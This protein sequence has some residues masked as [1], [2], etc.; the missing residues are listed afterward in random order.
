MPQTHLAEGRNQVLTA[1]LEHVERAD[2]LLVLK[3]PP[4]SGKTFVTTRAVALAMHRKRRVAVAAQTNAQADDFCRRMAAEFPR[5]PVHRWASAQ[6]GA[7]QLGDS[8]TWITRTA[9]LPA[10]PCVV[11]ATS[12]KWAVADLDAHDP[13]DV[14]FIDEAWQMCWADFMLLGTVAPRFVLVG[15]PGQI[16]PVVPIDVSRWQTSR[17]PPHVPAP[18]VIL[19]DRTLPVRVIELPVSTRLPHD[20]C[21]MVQSFYDFAFESWSA[22]G[23]RRVLL[24]PAATAHPVD[25]ALAL[26]TTGSVALMTLAT[27]PGGP[28]MEEDVALAQAAAEVVRRLLDRQARVVTEDGETALRPEDIGVSATH[29]VMNTRITDALGALAPKVRVDTPERWQGLER[30]VMV[31]VHPMSG[32]TQPTPFD[33]STGRLCVMASRHSVG[34]VLVSRDHVGDTLDAY[35]PVAAQALGQRDEAGRGRAQNL[36]LWQYLVQHQRV[37]PMTPT[38]RSMDSDAPSR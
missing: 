24:P 21:A 28:P 22:P 17:R 8:V 34:L 18:E 32:V 11:V 29:R 16:A 13:F 3:A 6:R 38:T 15:D 37:A 25:D 33:L 27:P 9:D 5:I 26:L 4:G 20:T 35:L 30:K 36:S 1:L 12:A 14:L 23:E 7:L 10:G 19:R 2:A 31:A